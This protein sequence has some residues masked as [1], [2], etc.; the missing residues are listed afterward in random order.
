[1]KKPGSF[2]NTNIINSLNNKISRLHVSNFQRNCPNNTQTHT[3]VTTQSPIN[4]KENRQYSVTNCRIKGKKTIVQIIIRQNN[5]ER[6]GEKRKEI[7]VSKLRE[8]MKITIFFLHLP[9]LKKKN[10]S[11]WKS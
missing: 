10:L 11:T 8:K 4:N 6:M 7:V 5:V 1:M 9:M 3:T 2:I